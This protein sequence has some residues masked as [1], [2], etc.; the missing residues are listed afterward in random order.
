MFLKSWRASR[1]MG[2]LVLKGMEIAAAARVFRGRA[3][4]I[5]LFTF[6][7]SP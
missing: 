7:Q 2:S 5:L 4:T 1:R 6:I 3:P